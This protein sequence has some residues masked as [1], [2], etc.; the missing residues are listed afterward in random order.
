MQCC[1]TEACKYSNFPLLYLISWVVDTYTQGHRSG[2]AKAGSI[3]QCCHTET[4]SSFHPHTY[5]TLKGAG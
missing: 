2:Y 3:I 1:A 4:E 5:K